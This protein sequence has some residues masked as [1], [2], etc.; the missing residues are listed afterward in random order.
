MSN[1]HK[2]VISIIAAAALMLL[3]AAEV[4]ASP[5][6]EAEFAQRQTEEQS[7][8]AEI[9]L[10][11]DTEETA[12]G[13]LSQVS[14]TADRAESDK[15]SLEWSYGYRNIAKNGHK[16][17]FSV[18]INN[19][20]DKDIDG[21]L[22]ISVDGSVETG[23][24]TFEP[25]VNSYSY[26]VSIPAQ[27]ETVYDNVIS[28]AG[29]DDLAELQLYDGDR[30]IADQKERI[31]ISS[32]DTELLIGILSD[33]PDRL[34]YYNGVSLAQTSLRARTI[35]LDA[36]TLPQNELELEQLDLIIISNFNPDRINDRQLN[37]IEAWAENGGVLLIGSGRDN[38]L[39]KRFGAFRDG[40][41]ISE[42]YRA[43][44]DMGMQYS[45]NGPDGAV[46]PLTV[47][48][49]NV[50]SGVQIMQSSD[51]AV[52]TVVN[53]NAG[54]IGFAAYDL[55]DI[56]EFCTQE[57]SFTD[58]LL[59]DL[60]GYSRIER[61]LNAAGSSREVYED[62]NE[63]M[64][65]ASPS[66]M[67]GISIYIIFALC[68]LSAMVLLY[69]KLRNR[70]LEL[71]YHAFVVVTAFAGAFVVWIMGSGSRYDG[72][73]I[74]YTAVREIH[75]KDISE[76]GYIRIFSAA[77]DGYS[78]SIPAG[79]EVYPIVHSAE[80]SD[81]RADSTAGSSSADAAG[82]AALSTD[83]S[84]HSTAVSSE[85]IIE[86]GT[87]ASGEKSIRAAG[88]GPFA[89]TLAEF[90]AEVSEPGD[91]DAVKAKISFSS[92]LFNGTAENNSPYDLEHAALIL[93]GR[94]LKLGRIKAGSS[95][96][97]NDMEAVSVPTAEPFAAAAYITGLDSLDTGDQDYAATL[98]ETRFLSNYI[99]D[100]L[101]SYYSGIRLIG[102]S[103]GEDIFDSLTADRHA[104]I[105]GTMLKAVSA[106]AELGSDGMVWRTAL[107]T[108][109]QVV[110]GDYDTASNT[111]RGTVV[112]EYSLGS[113]INIAALYF[114]G[115]SELF[116]T[117]NLSAFNGRISMYNYM[118]GGYD[119]KQLDYSYSGEDI[120]PYLS[121]ANTITVRYIP[122]DSISSG[123]RVF[124]PAPNIIGE[125]K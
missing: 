2:R 34:E 27:S 93:Y 12:E 115:L 35:E 43:N 64:G 65:V 1:V 39:A 60:L 58:D 53:E 74:D 21:R 84:E 109:P 52:L 118:T 77:S 92:E 29:A 90:S 87:K 91:G 17:P 120:A 33:T 54:T 66:D 95:I 82:R 50:Q 44:I 89:G 3:P 10:D 110:S 78:I 86:F 61:L 108:D 69:Y 123:A 124:L 97:I 59:T 71:Y 4:C 51:T 103:E 36:D 30:L 37:A 13:S 80:E 113:D 18:R 14:V 62:T 25:A 119:D 102:F 8:A 68:Y 49:I 20:T 56:D 23:I 38:R 22:V 98:K 19:G 81:T 105:S 99:A 48:S 104:D 121:P 31:S 11:T 28:V 40:F 107:S 24:D 83:A 46:L 55:C 6:T 100:S 15:V 16:L 75:G 41:E 106:E 111:T 117:E 70:G 101:G 96:E 57:I 63:F 32:D 5:A 45:K 122:D 76:S 67:P 85:R 26:E 94:V 73:S 9:V 72:L 88:L 112:L 42:P 79:Y 7:T 47:C 114:N 116:N 125:E